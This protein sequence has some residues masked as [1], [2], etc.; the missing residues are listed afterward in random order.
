M[1]QYAESTWNADIVYLLFYLQCPEHLDKKM[2][3]SLKLKVTK[4]YL[5]DQ[6]L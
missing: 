3:R 4:Y 1:E 6:Q 2:V 5:V